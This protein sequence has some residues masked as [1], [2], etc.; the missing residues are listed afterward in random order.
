MA[1]A[2]VHFTKDTEFVKTEWLRA[3]G[4]YGWLGVQVFF[5]I[6]GFVIPYSMYCGGY[7]PWQH[8]GRFLAKRLVRLEP[9]Y[10][11]SIVV[12]ITLW[13]L[14][15]LSPGFRGSPPELST[16]QLLCHVGYLNTFVGY[17]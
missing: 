9:P 10:L 4:D 6:S 12:F 16:P 7:R 1:V 2:W 14:S 17:A 8:F 5:V 15:A 3:S 11:V 13:Y